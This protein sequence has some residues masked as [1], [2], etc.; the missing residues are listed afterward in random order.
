[1]AAALSRSFS[2]SCSIFSSNCLS[3]SCMRLRVISSKEAFSASNSSRMASCSCSSLALNRLASATPTSSAFPPAGPPS[4]STRP[5]P[6]LA[7]LISLAWRRSS[8]SWA[9]R[10]CCARLCAAC[11]SSSAMS[12]DSR[13]CASS[14]ALVA[15]WADC[16]VRRSSFSLWC[17]RAMTASAAVAPALPPPP[18]AD[19]AAEICSASSCS[20]TFFL[21][22]ASACLIRFAAASASASCFFL[23]AS[24]RACLF[25]AK[26]CSSSSASLSLFAASSF[27]RASIWF[28]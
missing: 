2:R 10:C 16:C 7:A 4:P 12:G 22:I 28:K 8:A 11:A 15:T 23:A 25:F 13:S 20:A 21:S 6:D 18:I 1:M 19:V 27:S 24:L 9:S 14:A 3:S 5:T 17:L 26:R